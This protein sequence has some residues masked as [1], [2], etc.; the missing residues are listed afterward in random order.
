[1]R[2]LA[3]PPF[4]GRADELSLLREGL[5]AATGSRPSCVGSPATRVSA[6][7][8]CSPSSP[9]RPPGGRAGH[10]RAG[11]DLAPASSRSACSSRPCTTWPGPSAERSGSRRGDQAPRPASYDE[12]I[13]LLRAD[14]GSRRGRRARSQLFDRCS[15][16]SA[17]SATSSRSSWSS[18]TCT[19]PTGRASTCCSSSSRTSARSA[20]CSAI[21]PA[22][23]S[24]SS[25]PGAPTEPVDQSSPGPRP[26]ATSPASTASSTC[27]CR[28]SRTTRSPRSSTR[29]RRSRC[30]RTARRHRATDGTGEPAVR[31]AEPHRA[32][33]AAPPAPATR[34]RPY[35]DVVFRRRRR[36]SDDA[37][38]G[39]LRALNVIGRPTDHELLGR[40]HGGWDA[41]PP[42]QRERCARTWTTR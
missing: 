42:L 15:T 7:P 18:S 21:C 11:I 28:A 9:T 20:T 34:H 4:V 19:G 32:A 10:R 14:P 16:C 25:C 2:G 38:A 5:V 17:S 26:S 36:H 33:A 3:R 1:M 8:V 22:S 37:A 29:S 40:G 12:V 27:G 31:A 41:R 23:A 13:D 24:S 35:R 39:E 6:R 30:P